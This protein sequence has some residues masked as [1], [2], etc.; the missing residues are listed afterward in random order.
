MR[1][2]VP[3]TLVVAAVVAALAGCTLN[4]PT[5][6]KGAITPPADRVLIV[7]R[8]VTAENQPVAENAVDLLATALRDT[9][10]S[11]TTRDFLREATVTGAALWAPRL[12]ERIQRGGWPAA[13]EN[14]ELLERFGIGSL[15]VVEVT[16]YEQVWGRYAKFTRV[17]IDVHG[18][19]V[20][21]SSVLWRA[22]RDVEVED[23]RGRS[24]QYATEQAVW[25]LAAAIEGESRITPLEVWRHWRR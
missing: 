5:I 20:Q 4:S 14:G 13:E 8:A 9:R 25:D 17:G 18:Y 23:R 7:A 22:H 10:A 19:H 3:G 16:T 21:S 2:G 6:R 24:F 11:L 12:L 1:P 15:L